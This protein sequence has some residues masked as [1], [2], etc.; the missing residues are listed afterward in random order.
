MKKSFLLVCCTALILFFNSCDDDDQMVDLPQSVQDYISSNYPNYSIDESET[1]TSCTGTAIYEVEIE[2]SDDDELELTFDSEGTFLYSE[3]EIGVDEL[4]DA[5][6]SSIDTNY[7]DYSTEEAERLDMA[8]G[9]ARYEVELK[10]GS[11]ELDV[12]F[13]SDGTV[14]C[15]EEDDD[16]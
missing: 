8:D 13:E 11:T 12:L 9:S 2:A 5:V 6:T 14:V 3:T 10:N 15:E 7:S 1:D 4:P 16:E